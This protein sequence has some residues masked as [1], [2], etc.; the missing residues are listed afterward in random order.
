MPNYKSTIK[1][2]SFLYLEMKKA[3]SLYL[4]G[5]SID[6]IKQKALEDNIFLLKTQN[7]IKEIASTIEDR[8]RVLDNFLI[9]KIAQGNLETSKQITLYSILKTDRLFFEF[10]Q[11]VYREKYLLMDNMITSKD[12]SIFFQRKAEQSRR[13]ASWKDYTYYKLEQVY[14]RILLEA[15]YAIKNKTNIE[16]TRPIMEKDIIDHLKGKGDDFYIKAMLGEI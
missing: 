11:E 6:E 15:G 12:F 9:S 5:F 3:S 8:M 7:R 16:I 2:R 13:V 10:M 1:A 4:Q 14:K